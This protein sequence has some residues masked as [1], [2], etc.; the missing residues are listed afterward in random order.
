MVLSGVV[1]LKW[2]FGLSRIQKKVQKFPNVVVMGLFIDQKLYNDGFSTDKYEFWTFSL[3]L[4]S[5]L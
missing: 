2:N 4:L 5:G 3:N 1:I